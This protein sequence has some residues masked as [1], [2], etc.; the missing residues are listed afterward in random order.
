MSIVRD[1]GIY[2]DSIVLLWPPTGQCQIVDCQCG[3]VCLPHWLHSHHC[4]R[5]RSSSKHSFSSSR[6]PDIPATCLKHDFLRF[7]FFDIVTCP[8]SS[9]STKCYVNL[10]LYEWMNNHKV[11]SYS[12]CLI[13][14]LLPCCLSVFFVKTCFHVILNRILFTDP[15]QYI[16]K[17]CTSFWANS[18]ICCETTKLAVDSANVVHVEL[19]HIN[20][21]KH[22]KLKRCVH[23]LSKSQRVDLRKS[24]LKLWTCKRLKF[25]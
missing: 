2:L 10:F 6:I 24:P 3:S 4:Y 9:F 18:R 5:S 16:C 23:K 17:L 25:N 12:S 7:N 1:P 22:W 13:M 11:C 20:T 14:F 15:L 19:V 8:W 21:L